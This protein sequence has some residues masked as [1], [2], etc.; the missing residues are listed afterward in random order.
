M[1][2]VGR[3]FCTCLPIGII[4]CIVEGMGIIVKHVG[5]SVH[6]KITKKIV[7]NILNAA[8]VG[9]YAKIWKALTQ[10][11][12]EKHCPQKHICSIC[13]VEFL[14]QTTLANHSH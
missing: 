10:H 14:T 12:M 4:F 8:S 9:T 7:K 3:F 5:I 6:I 2:S 1:Q 11:N 13:K